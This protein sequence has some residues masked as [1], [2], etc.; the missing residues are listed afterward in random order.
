MKTSKIPVEQKI[1]AKSFREKYLIPGKPLLIK[2]LVEH[3]PAAKKWTLE[4]FNQ[5]CKD[6][7]VD[8]YDNANENKAT[9]FTKPDL[10]MKFTEY[11]KTLSSETPSNLRIFLFN[12]FKV[13]PELRKDFEC[14]SIM[15]GIL[16]R[17]GFMFFGAK[18]IR[19]RIHQ[20]MDF[21][22]VLLTQFYGRK[23]VVLVAPEYSEFIYKLPLNTHALIDLEKPD[24]EKYPGLQ[25]IE[26]M[27][28]VLEPGDS[29]FIPSGYWHDITYLDGGFSVSYRKMASNPKMFLKGI[30]S[31]FVYLPI[32]KLLHFLLGDKWLHGKERL[33]RFAA[34]RAIMN[35][36]RQYGDDLHLSLPTPKYYKL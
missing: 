35:A 25:Y 31:L 11:L 5:I 3:T 21:S 26:T 6:V 18:G 14:P 8:V 20:D 9:A 32:D 24:Y 29:L 30:L 33:A 1:S 19:V 7:I 23:K 12:M 16:S 17:F 2:N 22:N 34:D 27:D 4:Y 28:C 15:S 36:K 13:K 10:K